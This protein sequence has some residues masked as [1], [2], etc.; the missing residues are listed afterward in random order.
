MRF[1]DFLPVFEN[2]LKE[3]NSNTFFFFLRN[4]RIKQVFVFVVVVSLFG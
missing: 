2:I 4:E 1:S 3:I